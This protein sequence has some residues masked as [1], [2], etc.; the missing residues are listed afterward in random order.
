MGYELHITRAKFWAENQE[1]EISRD[2]W[3][4]LVD[5]DP[6]LRIDRHNGRYF[7]ELD[8]SSEGVWRWLNWTEGNI[9]TKNPDHVTLQ[10]MLQIADRLDAQVQGD[11]GERY[12]SADDFPLYAST[13]STDSDYE[14]ITPNFLRREMRWDWVMYAAVIL[15]VLA[16]NVFDFW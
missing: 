16:I 13:E 14:D 11:D 8:S 7:A 2:E 6:T 1:H 4:A 5:A 9:S 10:K 15:T 3:L 12:E